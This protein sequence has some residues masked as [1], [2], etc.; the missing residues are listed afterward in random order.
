MLSHKKFYCL[1]LTFWISMGCGIARFG[2]RGLNLNLNILV[3]NFVPLQ[4]PLRFCGTP[5]GPMVPPLEVRGASPLNVSDLCG[6]IPLTLC[7]YFFFKKFRCE[8]GSR[9]NI[10]SLCISA[11]FSLSLAHRSK[12]SR[13]HTLA[14]LNPSDHRGANKFAQIASNQD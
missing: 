1:N 13:D 14:Y 11:L 7:F 8:R 12:T 10:Y 4:H 5:W 9:D 2:R 6:T 3:S